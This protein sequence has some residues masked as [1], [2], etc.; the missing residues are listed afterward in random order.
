[1]ANSLGSKLNG[2][3]WLARLKLNFKKRKIAIFF[4]LE[5]KMRLN[6]LET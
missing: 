3:C 6:E 2:P 5:Q 4:P 1:M